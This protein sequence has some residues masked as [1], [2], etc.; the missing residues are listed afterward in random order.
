MYYAYLIKLDESEYYSG[1]TSDLKSRI[2]AH[3]NG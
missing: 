2:K 3:Q 1:S